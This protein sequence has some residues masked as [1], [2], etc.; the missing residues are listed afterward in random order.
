MVYVIPNTLEI[1]PV[2]PYDT[3]SLT[4][5]VWIRGDTFN[6]WCADFGGSW[7]R[8]NIYLYRRNVTTGETWSTPVS[9]YDCTNQCC[10]DVQTLAWAPDGGQGWQITFNVINPL[11]IT[12]G[13]STTYEFLAVDKGDQASKPEGRV[14]KQT[15]IVTRDPYCVNNPCSLTCSPTCYTCPTMPACAA[16]VS[17]PCGEACTP[18]PCTQCPAQTTCTGGNGDTCA[19]GDYLCQIIDYAKKNPVV[20]VAGVVVLYLIMS[21]PRRSK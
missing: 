9:T 4:A 5:T 13:N 18:R 16:C 6:V 7:T 14:A 21:P 3:E 1:T 15:V 10:L 12:S 11:H 20:V 2:D 19:S 17:D 8:T